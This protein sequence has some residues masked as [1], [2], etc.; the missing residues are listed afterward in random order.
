[1][2]KVDSTY[3]LP[4]GLSTSVNFQHFTGYP[5]QP[6]AYL[7]GGTLLNQG[8]E[9]IILRP[10][11]GVR[12]PGVNLL[13]LRLARD[14][15][16]RDRLTVKPLIDLFNLTNQQTLINVNATLPSTFGDPSSTYL[17]P[18]N[19]I[20]PFIARIGLRVDF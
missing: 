17:K 6:V 18:I 14:F 4:W 8:S 16:V 1:M 3:E 15:K 13:N 10:A 11:G 20:N 5:L 2:F 19:T 9:Q 7:G 12:L